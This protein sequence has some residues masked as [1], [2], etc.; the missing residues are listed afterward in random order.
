MNCVRVGNQNSTK[1]ETRNQSLTDSVAGFLF[2]PK[3]VAVLFPIIPK[4][5]FIFEVMSE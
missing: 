5:P 3:G 2:G 1:T 4:L